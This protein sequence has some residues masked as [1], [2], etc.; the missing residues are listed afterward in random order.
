MPFKWW[1]KPERA[2]LASARARPAGP[3]LFL[4]LHTGARGSGGCRRRR[5]EARLGQEGSAGRHAVAAWSVTL[6]GR[7]D[8]RQADQSEARQLA[9][10]ETRN[11]R[12]VDARGVLECLLS[13]PPNMSR[14]ADVSTDRP[15]A[16][17]DLVSNERHSAVG[18]RVRHRAIPARL[19]WLPLRRPFMRPIEWHFGGVF[20]RGRT[21]CATRTA[22][23]QA[24]TGLRGS[25]RAMRGTAS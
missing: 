5:R 4:H 11:H 21:A 23:P 14:G 20:P 16:V 12:L 3:R 2:H 15:E 18:S 1:H 6:E 8:G 9:V 17:I 19:P 13:P 24:R 25:F 7:D 10:L 22:V